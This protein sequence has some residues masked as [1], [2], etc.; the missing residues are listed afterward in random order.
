[1]TLEEFEN[2]TENQLR[3]RANDCFTKAEVSGGGD[4]PHL[5]AEAQF[6]IGEMER[7]KQG[8]ANTVSFW[9]EVGVIILILGEII[10]GIYEGN[11]QAQLLGKQTGILE[12]LDAS[13]SATSQT[14]QSLQSTTEVMNRG[15]QS[16]LA[17]F[18]DPSVVVS[19]VSTT[20]KLNVINNGRT[21]ISLWG[22]KLGES[23][24][25][26]FKQPYILVPTGGYEFSSEELY[27]QLSSLLSDRS[28]LSLPY[29]VYIKTEVG[30]EFVVHCNLAAFR[31]G[32]VISILTQINSIS[33]TKWS[34]RYKLAL[35][36]QKKNCEQSKTTSKKT[37]GPQRRA[38]TYPVT[39][40]Q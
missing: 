3:K 28:S 2:A 38:K 29:D 20:R 37:R 19:F 8:K 13:T 4:K 18:Y 24:A 26:L 35:I 6:Y 21:N 7:R 9:M 14:L 30:K 12:K 16:Q 1:M 15:V 10:M 32:E 23:P 40:G 25:T 22:S 34:T 36:I 33:P 27:R 31:Q 5:Y 11:V 17:L 39:S